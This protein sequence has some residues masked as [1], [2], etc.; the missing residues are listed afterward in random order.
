MQ[1]DGITLLSPVTVE[2]APAIS[3]FTSAS[4]P[5]TQAVVLAQQFDQDVLGDLGGAF[6]TFIDSGQVWALIVGVIVGYL[7]RGMTTYK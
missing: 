2:P 5:K 1:P 4:T 6:K 7:F 3:R